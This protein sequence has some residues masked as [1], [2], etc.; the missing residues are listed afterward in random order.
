[1]GIGTSRN[2]CR[3]TLID[4]DKIP[5]S[6]SFSS[7]K[8]EIEFEFTEAGKWLGIVMDIEDFRKFV[9]DDAREANDAAILNADIFDRNRCKAIKFKVE[10]NLHVNRA[11]IDIEEYYI[12]TNKGLIA[13]IKLD[14]RMVVEIYRRAAKA[15]L[16]EFKTCTFISKIA[17]DCKARVDSM[18]MEY[19]KDHR[20]FCYL[21]RNG[22]DDIKILIERIS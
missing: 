14:P 22:E 4:L 21:I 9:W 17:R 20:D 16:K 10:R 19:K 2:S 1:M 6:K 12:T 8:E 15:S 18:L 7:K 11:Q 13:W 5:Q 3:P